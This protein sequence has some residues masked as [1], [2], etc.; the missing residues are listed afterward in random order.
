MEGQESR[1]VVYDSYVN[2][3]E[4]NMAESI[5]KNL[6]PVSTDTMEEQELDT[7]ENI[8]TEETKTELC[9]KLT[10]DQIQMLESFSSIL[11][12][13]ENGTFYFIPLVFQRK[14]ELEEDV[15]QVHQ[16]ENISIRK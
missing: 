8:L 2:E 15:F 11:N 5:K 10:K 4:K 12:T 7:V 13:E 6:N 3:E 9:V 16:L 1:E 14:K